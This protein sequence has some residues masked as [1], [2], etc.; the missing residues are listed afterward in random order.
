M[1]LSG[2][3]RVSEGDSIQLRLL[4]TENET[5]EIDRPFRD[6]PLKVHL[7]DTT[8]DS[9][10]DEAGT[11][12]LTGTVGKMTYAEHQ[13]S[14]HLFLRP[15]FQTDQISDSLIRIEAPDESEEVAPHDYTD[16]DV[17]LDVE[18]L[19]GVE[20]TETQSTDR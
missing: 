16:T 10:F 5:F 4:Y 19:S 1:L 17:D 15:N 20:L 9:V 3:N 7:P 14:D 8:L 2:K 6:Q 18:S 12:E 13:G 11:Y